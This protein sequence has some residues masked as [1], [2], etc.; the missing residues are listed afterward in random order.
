MPTEFEKEVFAW[1]ND[2]PWKGG[3]SLKHGTVF[4]PQDV[5]TDGLGNILDMPILQDKPCF[6]RPEVYVR[7]FG[8]QKT[9]KQFGRDVIRPASRCG[10]CKI[11]EACGKVATERVNSDLSVRRAY[12]EWSDHCRRIHG[13]KRVCTG[14]VEGR[15]WE[16]FK[17]AVADHGPWESIN[18]ERLRALE[19]ATIQARR[20]KWRNDKVRQR[21]RDRD[22]RRREH[23]PPSREFVGNAIAERNRRAAILQEAAGDPTLAPSISKIGKRDAADTAAITAGVWLADMIIKSM[24]YDAPG[25]GVIAKHLVRWKRAGGRPYA[26]LKARMD[27]DLRRVRDLEKGRDPLW[28]KFDPDSDIPTTPSEIDQI[29]GELTDVFE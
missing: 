24:G 22:H 18:D 12:W 25:P 28:S 3:K 13:G 27:K 26:S 6:G 20:D 16:R 29:L 5:E 1:G 19:E 7:Q 10:S 17:R 8:R 4:T 2:D 21:E 11:G 23:L 14:P 15:M 9:I